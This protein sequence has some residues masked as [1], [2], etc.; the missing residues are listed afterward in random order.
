[1]KLV[2][3]NM[4][5]F[6]INYLRF[7]RSIICKQLMCSYSQL[8]NLRFVKQVNCWHFIGYNLID[9]LVEVLVFDCSVVIVNRMLKQS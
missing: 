2:L 6:E 4:F 3:R 1:M 8:C 7:R 9:L 5:H